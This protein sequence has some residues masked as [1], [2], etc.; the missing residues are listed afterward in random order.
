[1]S[2][3]CK[4]VCNLTKISPSRKWLVDLQSSDCGKDSEEILKVPR[5]KYYRQ[6]LLCCFLILN[7][8]SFKRPPKTFAEISGKISP[9]SS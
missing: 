4:S 7:R 9:P 6:W 1:M 3:E 5:K 8:L 2:E